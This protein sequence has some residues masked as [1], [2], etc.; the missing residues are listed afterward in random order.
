MRHLSWPPLLAVIL[1]GA[2]SGVAAEQGVVGPDLD[3]ATVKAVAAMLPEQP[4]GFGRP[5]SDRAA[6]SRLAKAPAFRAVIRGAEKL[7]KRPLPD[8]PD[9]LYL[10]FSRT[11][12]RNRWQRVARDRRG[13][14][15][16]YTLAEC[17]EAKGRFIPPLVET[18][19]TLAAERTWVMP[20]HDRSLANFKGESVTIDLGSSGLAVDLAM[21]AYLLGDT[22]P[23][24]ARTLIR[25]NLERRIVA[26]YRKMVAGKQSRYWLRSTNNWNAV[27][28]A[29]VTGVA[30]ATIESREERA[31]F[32]QAARTHV[33]NFLRGFTPDGY[34]SEG[35]GYWHYGFGHYLLLSEAIVQATGGRID[36]LARPDA[37]EPARFGHRIEIGG[38]VC[39]AFA[40]CSVGTAPSSRMVHFISRRFRLGADPAADGVLQTVS[41]GLFGSMMYSLPNAATQAPP[42]ETKAEGL[43]LRTWFKDAGVLIGRP[44]PG[45]PCRMGVAM[46]GGHN[47]EHHN[48]NDVGS[49]VVAVG[50]QPVLLDPGAE[51]YTARTFSSKRY[52][53]RV[54]NSFGH[55]VPRVAGALQQKGSKA[56]GK[57]LRTDFTDAADTLVL[58]MRSAYAVKGLETLERTFVYSRQGAGSLTVTDAVAFAEPQAFETA[59]VT[60]GQW[61]RAADG[62]LIVR[63][64]DEAV[65]VDLDARG[66]EVECVADEI[67]ED[68]RTP[69]LP[70]R[71]GIRFAK[72]V[73]A[74]RVTAR[75]TPLP[76]EKAK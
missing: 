16:D 76:A 62:A 3:E 8:Q 55:P 65:R 18:I 10:D 40:D 69:V 30:L 74:A 58:D 70:T 19:Q 44:R 28:L 25:E 50:R 47:A 51:V 33:T 27:C 11:G 45:T 75:I 7:V 21:A 53:S 46:K 71:I 1:I 15:D 38:G 4:A 26:P 63:W 13:R 42:C 5:I 52:E 29:N 32:I 60:L 54:L 17:L 43:A 22:L 39:P 24:G 66:G 6:W 23:A 14:I 61:E 2:A 73:T 56:R 36:L 35:L 31:W 34:C 9:D 64:K 72:P 59:L 20:A 49:Y 12:N 37:C 68:V 57:I 67:T 48:H 41:G